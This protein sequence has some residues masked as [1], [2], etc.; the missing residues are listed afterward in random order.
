[1]VLCTHQIV[2]QSVLLM[3]R[4]IGLGNWLSMFLTLLI[5]LV[6]YVIIVP[7]LK[8]MFPYFVGQKSLFK[9]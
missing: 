9:I 1:M 7:I 2:L 6:S 5:V 4:K 8:E 3:V